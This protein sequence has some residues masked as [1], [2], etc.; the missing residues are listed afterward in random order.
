MY[1]TYTVDS[2][3]YIHCTSAECAG[4]LALGILLTQAKRVSQVHRTMIYFTALVILLYSNT[5]ASCT[6]IVIASNHIF[7]CISMNTSHEKRGNRMD[8][9]LRTI[10]IF[11]N[12]SAVCTIL[13]ASQ[14]CYV[15]KQ[16]LM[17]V[18]VGYYAAVSLSSS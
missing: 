5:H 17:P 11:S 9:D 3:Y 4:Q 6:A 15:C 14:I 10:I 8:E 18:V 1:N 7:V 2:S 16:P 13:Y 12:L